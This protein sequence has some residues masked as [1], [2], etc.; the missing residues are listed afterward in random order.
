MIFFQCRAEI[1]TTLEYT[2]PTLVSDDDHSHTRDGKRVEATIAYAAMKQNVR[3]TGAKPAQVYA[4]GVLPLSSPVRRRMPLEGIA[5]RTLRNHGKSGD[6]PTVP[7]TLEDLKIEGKFDHLQYS[8]IEMLNNVNLNCLF[9]GP[10]A[11]TG[12]ATERR[13][14]LHDNGAEAV[15]RIL[16]FATDRFL[17]LLGN[18][19]QWYMD[20]N[21]GLA[22][23]LFQQLYVI[24]VPY[25]DVMITA[26]YILLQ[27]KSQEVY[28]ELF[29][30]LSGECSER[31][32]ELNPKQIY[33]DFE[34][35]VMNAIR[36][37][38]GDE[39]KIGGCFYHLCQ[40]T[41]RKI[42]NLGLISQY[43]HDEEFNLFCSQID[44][45]AFLPEPDVKDGMQYLQEI[46][47]SECE[48][49]MTYFDE[50]YVSGKVRNNASKGKQTASNNDGKVFLK[51]SSSSNRPQVKF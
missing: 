41:H 37:I 10:W 38:F 36:E 11:M 1:T 25:G 46:V 49:V 9:V 48:P 19:Q 14:L 27:N 45:L 5:K 12:E 7:Q 29:S 21:F 22:P 28:E 43:K 4:Q 47:S 42:Q 39:V 35:A 34:L 26:A 40:S 2:H 44:C 13:F 33:V 15:S 50:T 6:I 51:R 3:N 30:V 32:I 23:P 18:A 16:I 17:E 20:G 31:E 24:R 8:C